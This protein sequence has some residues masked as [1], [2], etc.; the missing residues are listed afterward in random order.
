MR[1]LA[2][3][4]ALALLGCGP[5]GEL[6][7]ARR[8]APLEGWSGHVH[9][10]AGILG[11]FEKH[12]ERMAEGWLR[13]LGID[14]RILTVRAA[15]EL[16]PDLAIERFESLRVGDGAPTGGLLIVLDAAGSRARIEVSYA[17]EGALPDVLVNAVAAQQLAPY[18]SYGAVGM[19]LMDVLHM[20]K[21]QVLAEVARGTLLLNGEFVQRAHLAGGG[22]AHVEVPRLPADFELKR[23]VPEARRS[24][25]APAEDPLESVEAFLRVLNDFA[26]DPSLP[27]FTP[28]SRIQRA[29]YP[30]APF[31]LAMRRRVLEESK[32][33]FVRREGDR[34]VVRSMSPRPGFFPVLL[35]RIDGLWRV[36]LVELWKNVFFDANG[37]YLLRN[38]WT[39][40]LFGLVDLPGR[41]VAIDLSPLPLG[42]RSLDE[43]L[44]ELEQRLEVHPDARGQLRLAELLM[45]NAFVAVEALAHYEAAGRLAPDDREIA[46]IAAERA[47]YLYLYEVAIPYLEK[48]GPEGWE[49]LGDAHH[50][51]RQLEVAER[52]YSKALRRQPDSQRLRR[53]RDRVRAAL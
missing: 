34:A 10:E 22:G 46:H 15:E 1:W 44:S 36:D 8:S 12:L 51:A 29:R 4:L 42:G 2:F 43:T 31:E 49:R 25:Y 21:S 47:L 23:P 14:A 20:L 3:A 9:D 53:K 48:L 39:P 30:T 13:D 11:A 41:R 16:L 6:P 17:L 27:L 5:D 50:G 45:R 24:L 37:E 32:P 18:A 28:G 26:G 7:P 40:Y 19:A 52:Y 35:H 38:T 33:F